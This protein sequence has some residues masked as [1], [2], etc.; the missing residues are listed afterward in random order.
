MLRCAAAYQLHIIR[1]LELTELRIVSAGEIETAGKTWAEYT[2]PLRFRQYVPGAPETFVRIAKAWLEFHGM[3]ALPPPPPFHVLLSKYT[4]FLRSARGLSASTV[5]G[6]TERIKR[7]MF[8]FAEQNVEFA[9]V[10]IHHVDG[11]LAMRRA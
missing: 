5:T 6:Y 7:F 8:W 4:I 11:Y 1:I 3:L 10:S 9:S 2:G